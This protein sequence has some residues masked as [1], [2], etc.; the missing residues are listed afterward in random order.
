MYS[1]RNEERLSRPFPSILT[2]RRLVIFRSQVV[3]FAV[4]DGVPDQTDSYRSEKRGS[5][6]DRYLRP[7]FAPEMLDL[8]P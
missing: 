1:T 2:S 4:P 6:Y 7:P 3:R 5:H 8:R